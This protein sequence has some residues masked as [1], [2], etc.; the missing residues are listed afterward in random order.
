VPSQFSP[1]QIL[2]FWFEETSPSQRFTKDLEF[3][4]LVERRFLSTLESGIRGEL[5]SWRSSHEG[6]LAEIIVLDQFSRNIFRDQPQAYAQDS[7]ALELSQEALLDPAHK[8]LSAEYRQFLYMPFMH[9][10]SLPMHDIA[11]K[12]YS[13]PGL[14]SVF[15]FEVHHRNIIIKFGRYPHRN[16]ILGRESTPEELSFLLGPNSSF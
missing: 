13:E 16:R 7:M 14:E 12:L 9:S 1:E 2:A 8:K 5:H 6:R 15:E 10:E 3:D 11:M 4:R